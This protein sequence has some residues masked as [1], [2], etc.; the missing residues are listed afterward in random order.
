[1]QLEL[2]EGTVTAAYGVITAASTVGGFFLGFDISRLMA[3]RDKILDEVSKLRADMRYDY[4]VETKLFPRAY[5]TIERT[6]VDKARQD[7]YHLSPSIAALIT[8]AL[9]YHFLFE[10]LDAIGADADFSVHPLLRQTGIALMF[11]QA[12]IFFYHLAV[13]L[14][15]A[16]DIRKTNTLDALVSPTVGSD[17]R[18]FARSA[19]AKEILDSELPEWERMI[20]AD[21]QLD[22]AHKRS[23]GR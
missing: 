19:Q 2:S 17:G 16:N 15:V 3:T 18:Y 9:S 14:I 11:L 6:L 7:A 13:L 20:V 23:T 12:V 10:I 5:L 4:L 21:S 1:M 8:F 22:D